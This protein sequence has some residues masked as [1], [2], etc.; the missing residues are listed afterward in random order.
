MNKY[1]LL[2]CCSRQPFSAS[3]QFLRPRVF[4]RRSSNVGRK[5]CAT[6]KPRSSPFSRR[7]PPLWHNCNRRPMQRHSPHRALINATCVKPPAPRSLCSPPC[8]T[9][10]AGPSLDCS[11]H[12][13]RTLSCTAPALIP[14]SRCALARQRPRRTRHRPNPPPP[15]PQATRRPRRA[16]PAGSLSPPPALPSGPAP[17][18]VTISGSSR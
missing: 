5:H 7:S 2:I 15:S 14:S 1:R 18:R 9:R 3:Q 13:A 8:S 12:P 16:L 4:Q 10:K 6:M 17:G 11:I